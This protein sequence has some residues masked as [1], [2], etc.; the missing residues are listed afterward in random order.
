[1][2]KVHHL[3]NS[4]SQRILWTLE[5]TGADYEIVHYARD[6]E[7]GLAPESLMKVHP[8]GKSPIVEDGDTVIAE[9]AAAIDYLVR[10][11]APG[12]FA[13]AYDAPNYQQYNE[14]MHYIEGSAMLPLILQL[15]VSRLGEAGAPLAPRIGSEIAL[16]LGYLARTLGGQPFFMGDDIS[17]VDFH[18]TFIFEAVNAGGGLA[19]IPNLAAYL[20]RMEDRPAY[21]RA[22]ERGGPYK[23]GG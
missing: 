2:I 10:T 14:L 21:Q 8:L 3:N 11:Y 7:T 9:S 12:K 23:L 6:A 1:M 22:L 17:A 16:H 20:K 13:P 15:Y 5:E 4:R 18:A 19:Q